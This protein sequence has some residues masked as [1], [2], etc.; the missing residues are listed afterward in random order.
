MNCALSEPSLV[1]L[2]KVFKLLS[3]PNRLRIL[4]CLG[5]DC[6]P[7]SDILRDTGL[8]QT[9]A[10]FH[11]RILREAG[12]V[13]AERRGP[14][15]YYCVHDTS[16]W[17]HLKRLDHWVTAATSPG[18]LARGNGATRTRDAR[19]YPALKEA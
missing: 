6:R 15:I 5:T 14:F 4:R 17:V 19:D 13:R 1:R 16:L 18:R 9:N 11:L 12:L 3:E 7:V 10:S 2:A 8:E